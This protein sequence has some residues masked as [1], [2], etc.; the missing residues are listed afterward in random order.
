MPK[1]NWS[2]MCEDVWEVCD[3]LERG[4]AASGQENDLWI[5]SDICWYPWLAMGGADILT[6]LMFLLIFG[7]GV[8]R[9]GCWQWWWFDAADAAACLLVCSAS[10]LFFF[11]MSPQGC[12]VESAPRRKTAAWRTVVTRYAAREGKTQIGLV[13]RFDVYWLYD[14]FQFWL[15]STFI[16]F[17]TY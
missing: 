13:S 11:L 7:K 1:G 6:L 10:F 2:I 12:R 4:W 9:R 3:I 14:D 15:F 17:L 16:D 8:V 5:V